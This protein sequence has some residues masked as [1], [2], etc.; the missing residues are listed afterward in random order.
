DVN[1]N[2]GRWGNVWSS[3]LER[4]GWI[5]GDDVDPYVIDVSEYLTSGRHII[6]YQIEGIRPREGDNYGYWRT[7]SY[8]T[9]F[10]TT[11]PDADFNDDGA[12]DGRDFLIWQR[13]LGM[14]GQINNRRG[15]AN[16]DGTV[17]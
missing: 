11:E 14:S 6:E 17:D 8:L 15:D 7:S 5:P 2:S 3:D 1:P 10:L 13:G 9:G 16:R 12:V 4:S